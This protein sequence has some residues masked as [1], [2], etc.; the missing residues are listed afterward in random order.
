MTGFGV[1]EGRC[2]DLREGRVHVE[3]RSVNSRFLELKIRQPY[4][5]QVEHQL[6]QRVESAIHR[7]RVDVR[8]NIVQPDDS[9]DPSSPIAFGVSNSS[10]E[11]TLDALARIERIAVEK[12]VTLCSSSSLDILRY[13][14][15][16][17]AT[18]ETAVAPACL[19]PTLE[20]ALADLEEMRLNEGEALGDVLNELCGNLGRCVIEL[21]GVLEGESERIHAVRE[22]KIKDLLSRSDASAL[23]PTRLSQEV[24]LLVARGDIAEEIARISSHL[25]QAKD[26][27]AEP[28]ATGQGKRLDFLAQELLREVSTIGSKVTSHEG[29]AIVIALKAEVE[30]IREQVQ[31]VQ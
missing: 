12:E 30:R 17:G 19:L 20:R 23:D 14:A 21:E 26:V 1:A 4:G 29:S 5:P 24:A 9:A 8:I 16:L 27:L 7:G 22:A 28:D 3:L 15:S 31:N 25:A 10:V 11:R 6:R 18:T 2:D 13:S